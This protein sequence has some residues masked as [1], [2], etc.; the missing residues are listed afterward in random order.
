VDGEVTWSID[1]L[2][3]SRQDAAKSNAPVGNSASDGWAEHPPPSE[4][5]W[6]PPGRSA[7]PPTNEN[8]I[9]SWQDFS[10]FCCKRKTFDREC[11]LSITGS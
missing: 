9:Q 10:K 4:A 7:A 5:Y 8:C 1:Q 3:K 2:I 6:G 11:D